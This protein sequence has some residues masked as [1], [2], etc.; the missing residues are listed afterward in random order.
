MKLFKEIGD[1]KEVVLKPESY[2]GSSNQV[3]S[4]S[5]SADTTAVLEPEKMNII[6]DED[7]NHSDSDSDNISVISGK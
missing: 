7:D 1:T 4:E 3:Q 6:G 2:Q 5:M